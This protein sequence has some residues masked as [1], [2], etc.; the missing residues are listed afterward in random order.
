[1]RV[2]APALEHLDAGE[3][4]DKLRLSRDGTRLA[5]LVGR[6]GGKTLYVG[7]VSPAGLS[8]TM[9]RQI[10]P[11]LTNVVDVAWESADSLVVLTRNGTDATL[12][13]VP[14][15][16]SSADPMTTSGLPGPPAGVAAIAGQPTLTVAEGGVWALRGAEGGW[17]SIPPRAGGVADAAPA[18]PG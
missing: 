11:T 17:V 15:D 7:T 1:V 10:V 16:G 14:V 2:E 9:V 18:Y 3:R 4:I 6:P 13:E 12:W 8:L 5:V